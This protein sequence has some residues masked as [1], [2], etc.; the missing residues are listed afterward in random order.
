MADDLYRAPIR[1]TPKGA[2]VQLD[3][4]YVYPDGHANLTFANGKNW[5]CTDGYQVVEALALLLRQLQ[6]A[7]KTRSV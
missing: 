1:L 5:P 4:L 3:K 2:V 6:K 7:A